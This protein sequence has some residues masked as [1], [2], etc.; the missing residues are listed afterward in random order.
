[1]GMQS[2]TNR[3]VL[4]TKPKN[5]KYAIDGNTDDG[6]FAGTLLFRYLRHPEKRVLVNVHSTKFVY[7]L[8]SSLCSYR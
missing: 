7:S 4:Y 1:M 3:K 2:G 5:A 6:A 8:V